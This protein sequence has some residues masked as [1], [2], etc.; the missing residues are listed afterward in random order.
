P[1]ALA[2]LKGEIKLEEVATLPESKVAPLKTITQNRQQL[3]TVNAKNLPF[4]TACT[5]RF[6]RGNQIRRSGNIARKQSCTT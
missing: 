4:C 1:L 2:D 5:S 3:Q 6:K